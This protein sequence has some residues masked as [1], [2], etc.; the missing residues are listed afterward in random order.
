MK[1]RRF[2]PYSSANASML[3]AGTPVICSAHKGVRVARVGL[4]LFRP[5]AVFGPISPVGIPL[6]EELLHHHCQSTVRSRPRLQMQIGLLCCR[7]QI[8][9][10]YD[11]VCA[12]LP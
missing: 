10:H 11:P 1:L 4:E 5:V 12:A 9:I 6:Q 8:G 7:C 3:A 2:C